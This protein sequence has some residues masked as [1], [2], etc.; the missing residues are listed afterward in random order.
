MPETGKSQSGGQPAV[1]VET[2]RLRLAG[3]L[4]VVRES[5]L[6]DRLGALRELHRLTA[7]ARARFTPT[8]ELVIACERTLLEVDTLST[9]AT[10]RLARARELDERAAAALP[11]SSRERRTVANYLASALRR[12]DRD[13]GIR[14][15]REELARREAVF[16]ADHRSIRHSRTNLCNALRSHGASMAELREAHLLL[17]QEWRSRRDEFGVANPFTWMAAH[18]YVHNALK[19]AT[20]GEPLEEPEALVRHAVE[21]VE[22]RQRL[23]GPEHR[24][25]VFARITLAEAHGRAGRREQAIW[26]LL[27]LRAEADQV[28][29]DMPERI[30]L[31]LME[32]LGES[33][34]AHDRIAATSFGREARDDLVPVY[35]VDHPYVVDVNARIGKIAA[36]LS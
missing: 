2:D 34:D 15:Y 11:E 9:T 13:A 35:G 17:T 18:A 5:S 6:R 36:T 22:A 4:E 16:P 32:F 12:V 21:V 33:S 31:L 1:V 3:M 27:A 26:S 14:A 28:G 19:A 7:L 10:E 30:P 8:D 29:L 24:R 25:T 23:L 20:M